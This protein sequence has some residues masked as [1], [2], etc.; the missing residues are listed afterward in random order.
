M[1][2]R[3]RREQQHRSHAQVK[4]ALGLERTVLGFT[5][6]NNTAEA[7]QPSLPS[8]GPLPCTAVTCLCG[9]SILVWCALAWKNFRKEKHSPKVPSRNAVEMMPFFMQ[10][11]WQNA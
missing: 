8:P 6:K 10:F 3:L 2:T 9:T 4:S 1:G 5:K 11:H 7:A